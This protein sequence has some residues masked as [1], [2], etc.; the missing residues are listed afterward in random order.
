MF[1]GDLPR[2]KRTERA[3]S[4]LDSVGMTHRLHHL[5]GKLSGGERQRVA[6][7]RSLANGPSILLA[8]EPTGNLDSVN[9]RIILDLLA[10][11]HRRQAM[12]LVMVTH[13]PAIARTAG[14]IIHMKDGKIESGG[15]SGVTAA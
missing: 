11:L 3:V 1:E 5:P 15:E 12:T 6:I 2:S 8:D 9:A 10:E 7:A 13:D 4:L 14:R